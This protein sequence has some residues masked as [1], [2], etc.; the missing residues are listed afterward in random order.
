MNRLYYGNNTCYTDS[1]FNVIEIDYIGALEI[2]NKSTNQQTIIERNNKIDT[3][4]TFETYNN[5][6]V[7]LSNNFCNSTNALFLNFVKVS[8]YMS[9][10]LSFTL[11][12]LNTLGGNLVQELISLIP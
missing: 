1:V 5:F 12:L 10:S 8:L 9:L 3:S 2:D 4:T 11:P 7:L 6:A